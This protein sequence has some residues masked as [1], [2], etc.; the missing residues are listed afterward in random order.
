MGISG[1]PNPEKKC[2]L[3]V[4]P[5]QRHKEYYKEVGGASPKFK[6]G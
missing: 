6:S 3:D 5:M 1:L 4:A 2:H